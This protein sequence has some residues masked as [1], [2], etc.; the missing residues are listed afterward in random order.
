MLRDIQL[1]T[2]QG[3]TN[4]YV[5]VYP[6]RHTIRDRA[7]LHKQ[8]RYGICYETYDEGLGRT[9]QSGTLWYMRNTIP[10]GTREGSTNRYV[11]VYDTNR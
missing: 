8:V 5:M 4:R 9:P 10:L 1:G 7:G 3:S 2:G 11:M 6:T